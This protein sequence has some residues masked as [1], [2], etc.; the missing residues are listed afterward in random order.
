VNSLPDINVW[1]ALTFSGHPHHS[2]ALTWFD[3]RPAN[4]CAFCRMTQQGYLRL[5]SNPKLFGA[6]TLT[7]P[8]A[9]KAYDTALEDERVVFETEPAGVEMEWRSLTSGES[10][11][12]KI[13]NDAFLAAFA[14]QSAL[15]LVTFDRGFR[16][17]P[18]LNLKSLQ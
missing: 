11:S 2:A 14:K 6:D 13:W 7:L 1:L 15:Q 4:S 18:G 3:G 8:K 5:A 10:F 9:W 12:A 16:R 17:Y